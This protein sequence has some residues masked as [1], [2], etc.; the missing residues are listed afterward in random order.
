MFE[1]E[2]VRS[3]MSERYAKG[4]AQA[5]QTN[6]MRER[7]A[8][9]GAGAGENEESP[10]KVLAAQRAPGDNRCSTQREDQAG[11]EVGELPAFECHSMDLPRTAFLLAPAGFAVRASGQKSPISAAPAPS[12]RI[13]GQVSCRVVI[14]TR[15]PK[16]VA[17]PAASGCTTDARE[18]LGEHL[19][20]LQ[21]V[22]D[23]KQPPGRLSLP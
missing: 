6:A 7:A 11:H 23:A 12:R 2:G 13:I 14:V 15:A 9:R 8:E 17:S 16:Q 18:D 3:E 10:R 4:D 21:R 1:S 19:I 22:E 5:D 20:R